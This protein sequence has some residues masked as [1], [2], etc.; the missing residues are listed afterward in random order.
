VIAVDRGRILDAARSRG[1]EGTEDEVR[2]GG[3]RI[4]LR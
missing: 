4:H 1:L 2:V 3:V